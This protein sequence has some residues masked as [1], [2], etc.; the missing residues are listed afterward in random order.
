[1][2]HG[3]LVTTLELY[4]EKQ[5]NGFEKTKLLEY[6]FKTFNENEL[7]KLEKMIY[8]KHSKKWKMTPDICIIQEIINEYNKD[9]TGVMKEYR[10][11][12]GNSGCSS[13]LEQNKVLEIEQDDDEED[14]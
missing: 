6:L 11:G 7:R 1:M 3:E 10:F 5:Y 13:L 9:F 8:L 14:N 2:N 12:N 4:Y